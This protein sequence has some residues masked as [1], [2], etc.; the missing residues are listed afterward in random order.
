MRDFGGIGRL[1]GD[2]GKRGGTGLGLGDDDL[3]ILVPVFIAFGGGGGGDVNFVEDFFNADNVDGGCFGG[4]G[5][6]CTD[7]FAVNSADADVDVVD[8]DVADVEE[9]IMTDASKFDAD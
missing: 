7:G 9:L 6:G 5:A 4:R 2:I 8:V 3:V 1:G